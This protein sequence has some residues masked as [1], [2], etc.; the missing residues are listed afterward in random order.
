MDSMAREID[1]RDQYLRDV[2]LHLEN[3][4]TNST[5]SNKNN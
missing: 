1:Q 4:D 2:L 3:M 5:I